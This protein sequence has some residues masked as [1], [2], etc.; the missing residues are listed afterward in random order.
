MLFYRAVGRIPRTD[1]P[2][3][4]ESRNLAMMHEEAV[5]E[6]RKLLEAAMHLI[7]RKRE[8]HNVTGGDWRQFERE[9]EQAR[10]FI[11]TEIDGPKEQP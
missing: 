2:Q 5:P 9:V 4:Y 7:F 3:K 1:R 6:F 11:E 8:F 10:K